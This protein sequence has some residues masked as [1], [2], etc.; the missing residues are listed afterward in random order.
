VPE[1]LQDKGLFGFS[2]AIDG[3]WPDPDVGRPV[4][5]PGNRRSGPIVHEIKDLMGSLMPLAAAVLLP[6]QKL[7]PLI[8]S[9]AGRKIP[10]NH[11]GK[12]VR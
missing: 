4:R 8:F 9:P 2:G 12:S 3:R 6:E 11:L 5:L 1:S 10:N 7:T